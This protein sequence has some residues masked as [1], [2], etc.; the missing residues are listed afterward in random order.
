MSVEKFGAPFLM[1]TDTSLVKK[2]MEN[3]RNVGMSTIAFT[4]VSMM[5]N[6]R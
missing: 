3:E 6:C 1:E 2:M 4:R 5:R